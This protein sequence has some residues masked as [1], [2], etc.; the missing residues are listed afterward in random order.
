MCRL[1]AEIKEI[2]E[3]GINMNK[4][5]IFRDSYSMD[6]RYSPDFSEI[7]IKNKYFFKWLLIWM[8]QNHTLLAIVPKYVVHTVF[9]HAIT[10]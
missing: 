5:R 2:L 6:L 4:G 8:A 7:S 9:P 10:F 3:V 1:S